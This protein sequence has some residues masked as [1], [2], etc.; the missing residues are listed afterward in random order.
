MYVDAPTDSS[1]ARERR[2]AEAEAEALEVAER[3]R[4]DEVCR[5]GWLGEDDEGRPILCTRCRPHLLHTPC[6]TCGTTY[7]ACNQ[8]L[9]A[10]RGPCCDQHDHSRRGGRYNRAEELS[11]SGARSGS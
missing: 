6:R 5:G 4:H 9:A 3:R 10:R 1:E 7:E 8:Q 2:E 11:V